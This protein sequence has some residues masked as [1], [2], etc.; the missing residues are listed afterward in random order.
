MD[1]C[2]FTFTGFVASRDPWE[3]ILESGMSAPGWQIP[4][5]E[6]QLLASGLNELDELH[7]AFALA[8]AE[9]SRPDLFIDSAITF[10][11]HLSLSVRINAYRVLRAVPREYFDQNIRMAI[12]VALRACPEAIEFADIA[13][14]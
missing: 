4:V 3:Y 10:L 2:T 12:M 1:N 13:S 5:Q 8:L 7:L 6:L 14:K 9:N 11:N